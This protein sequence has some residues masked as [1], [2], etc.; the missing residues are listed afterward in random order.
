MKSLLSLEGSFQ[1][2]VWYN[3]SEIGYSPSSIYSKIINS[4][5]SKL[6]ILKVWY[7]KETRASD[8]ITEINNNNKKYNLITLM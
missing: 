6:W 4:S 5:P 3:D 1:Y 2:V 7:I 8:S